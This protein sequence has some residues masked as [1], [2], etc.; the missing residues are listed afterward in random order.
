MAERM[1]VELRDASGSLLGQLGS[2]SRRADGADEVEEDVVGQLLSALLNLGYP[3][4][5][6]ERVVGVAAEEAGEG[7]GIEVLIRTALRRLAR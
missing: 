3:R 4:S 7:A 6:A 5:Q 2:G 1:G